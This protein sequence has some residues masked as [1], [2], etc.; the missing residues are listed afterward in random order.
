MLEML[1]VSSI[2]E[3][4]NAIF[5]TNTSSQTTKRLF[6]YLP[7]RFKVR[8]NYCYHQSK[9]F[10]TKQLRLLVLTVYRDGSDVTSV[11]DVCQTDPLPPLC[12]RLPHHHSCNE[13]VIF[14]PYFELNY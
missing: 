4:T 5:L 6:F 7:I 2:C 8:F 10:K 9:P 12:G 13:R 11:P 14:L 1:I 3:A